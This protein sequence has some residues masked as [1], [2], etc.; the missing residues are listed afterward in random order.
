MKV[1][2]LLTADNHSSVVDGI[3]LKISGANLNIEHRAFEKFS[4][5]HVS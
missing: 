5:P 2:N 4:I 1:L 3:K